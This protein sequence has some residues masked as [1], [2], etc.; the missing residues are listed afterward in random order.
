MMTSNLA[1][2]QDYSFIQRREKILLVANT[3]WYLYNFRLPLLSNLREKGLDVILVS[4]K[5]KYT[6]KLEERGFKWIELDL[7]RRSVN[8]FVELK[9]L[10]KL[11]LIYWKERPDI[12]HHFTIKCVL[13][14]TFA[15]KLSGISKV[16]NAITGLG[17]IYNNQSIKAKLLNKVTKPLYFL[18]LNAKRSKVVF[19]NLDDLK[20]LVQK[21]YTS[22]KK[23]ILIPSSGVDVERFH[24]KHPKAD[25]KEIKV[26]LASRLV[27]D[28][29]INEYVKAAE[30][31]KSQGYSVKFILAGALYPD[32]PTAIA[33]E[34]ILSWT[35]QGI[36][37][38]LGHIDNIEDVIDKADIVVLPSHGGEGVPKILI[39]AAAMGKALISTD[40][41]GCRDVIDNGKNG[42]LVPPKQY[43][44]LAKAIETLILE[45]DLRVN[46]GLRSRDKAIQDF[47]V[48][49]VIQKTVAVYQSMGIQG[50]EAVDVPSR[51]VT[52]EP[53][54]L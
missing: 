1:Q 51:G 20:L 6:A 36:I 15:A 40:V 33:K 14:G 37:Q 48:K 11:F 54:A 42:F 21:K 35:H 50:V 39:E 24:F 7:N 53:I 10:F 5:D 44:P 13:Y 49:D 9:S 47:N 22:T 30:W 38:W 31:I 25:V 12:V 28:K 46:M 3:G 52:L 32:N 26:L 45:P 34:K 29:G 23:S 8:P 41:S 27:A 18:V 4:P 17:Y 43:M 19:Q 16:V 2:N